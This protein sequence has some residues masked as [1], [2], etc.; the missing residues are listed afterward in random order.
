VEFHNEQTSDVDKKVVIPAENRICSLLNSLV[1]GDRHVLMIEHKIPAFLTPDPFVAQGQDRFAI[2][3][4]GYFYSCFA[5]RAHKDN[6]HFFASGAGVRMDS[7]ISLNCSG[8]I[9]PFPFFI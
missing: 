3:F 9:S 4:K 1:M 5:Y 6:V 2:L 7:N 8:S